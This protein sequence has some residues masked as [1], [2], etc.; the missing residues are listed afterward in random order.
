MWVK[1]TTETCFQCAEPHS[2]ERRNHIQERCTWRLEIQRYH[3]DLSQQGAKIVFAN[4]NWRSRLLWEIPIWQYRVIKIHTFHT[5]Y[6]LVSTASGSANTRCLTCLKHELQTS[7]IVRYF[8]KIK[9]KKQ[10]NTKKQHIPSKK[11]KQPT[12]QTKPTFFVKSPTS[13]HNIWRN[14]GCLTT[15]T[16]NLSSL[17]TSLFGFPMF[18]FH[19]KHQLHW[20]GWNLPG[21][22]QCLEIQTGRERICPVIGKANTKTEF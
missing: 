20:Q 7:F 14:W 1:P 9:Q 18:S 16:C 6:L 5:F 12:K 17:W 15:R 10:E 21:L 19:L 11:E 8:R 22:H 2:T 13:S 3:V 4:R